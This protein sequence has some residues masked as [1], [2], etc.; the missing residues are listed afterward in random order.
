MYETFTHLAKNTGGD[1]AAAHSA[2]AEKCR[3][4]LNQ[5]GRD[6]EGLAQTWDAVLSPLGH[7]VTL[8]PE[9]VCTG[10]IESDSIPNPNLE[11]EELSEAVRNR[12]ADMESRS[13]AVEA[14]PYRGE[15]GTSGWFFYG[16]QRVF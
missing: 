10:G 14:I 1:L 15:D 13:P 7:I 9:D 16:W 3:T 11:D 5:Q 6:W 8:G 2:E 12:L 4:S